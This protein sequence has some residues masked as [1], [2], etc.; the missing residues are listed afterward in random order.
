[1]PSNA[2]RDRPKKPKRKL[3]TQH[4]IAEAITNNVS[5]FINESILGIS[6]SQTN[7][8]VFLAIVLRCS[9]WKQSIP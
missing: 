2:M 7:T 8:A 3:E 1:M 5:S 4:Q 6:L 9:R